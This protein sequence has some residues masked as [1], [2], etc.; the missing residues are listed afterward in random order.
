MS[1]CPELLKIEIADRCG[2]EQPGGSLVRAWDAYCDFVFRANKQIE[3]S[4]EGWMGFLAAHS[5]VREE[6]EARERELDV[7]YRRIDQLILATRHLPAGW[8]SPATGDVAT[9]MGRR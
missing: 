2:T 5:A 9:E 4:R 8:D 3:P 7:A 6:L 1:A